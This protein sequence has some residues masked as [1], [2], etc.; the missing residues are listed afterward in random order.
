MNIEDVL[1]INSPLAPSKKTIVH[2][3]YTGDYVLNKINGVLKPFDLTSQQY[4]VL[5]ILRGQKGE[6]VSLSTIQ[7]RM[8]NKNSNT[9]RLL[10]K[11][12]IKKL[13]LREVDPE[14]RRK[15]KVNI[16]EQGKKILEKIDPLVD[17]VE[18]MTTKNL[19]LS[20]MKTLNNLL[21]RIRH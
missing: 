4:N 8:I 1:R 13:V 20:E 11:L 10:D 17:A 21:E 6:A 19:S 2:M 16:T 14:N 18:D 15:L 5:R 9:T 12:V 3:M 7:E